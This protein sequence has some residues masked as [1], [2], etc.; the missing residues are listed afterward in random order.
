MTDKLCFNAGKFEQEQKMAA[1]LG[2]STPLWRLHSHKP[3]V[4][5]TLLSC[6]SMQNCWEHLRT[7]WQL[8][9]CL[10]TPDRFYSF[11]QLVTCVSFLD[12]IVIP[13]LPILHQDCGSCSCLDFRC[14]ALHS[15]SP[16]RGSLTWWRYYLKLPATHPSQ[17]LFSGFWQNNSSL[18]FFH[19]AE[20]ILKGFLRN[21]LKNLWLFCAE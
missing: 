2:C 13:S 9:G 21:I 19:T 18:H 3:S 7:K 10:T 14:I 1:S 12:A 8:P 5:S 17:I 4:L 16:W 6:V 20:K 15:R 11:I